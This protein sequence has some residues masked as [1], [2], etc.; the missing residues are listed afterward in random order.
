MPQISV[1]KTAD[2]ST[3][4]AGGT[5]HYTVT[6]TNTG[7]IAANGTTVSDPIP[8]GIASQ[9]WVCV[10]NGGATCAASGNGAISDTIATFPAGA[11]AVYTTTAIVAANPPA[12][13]VNTVSSTPPAGG[14]CS[15]GGT[16]PPCTATVSTAATAPTPQVS[17]SKTENIN[18]LMPG[19]TVVYTVTV[20]NVGSV[21]VTGATVTDPLPSGISAFTWTCTGSGGAVCPN[22]SGS[23][24]VAETIATFPAGSTLIY[25][26]TATIAA[27]PPGTVTN[28]ASL[29]PPG[30]AICSPSGN[31]PPCQ[32]TAVGTVSSVQPAPAPTLNTW[33]KIFLLLSLLGLGSRAVQLSRRQAADRRK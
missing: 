21:A 27:S 14:L 26:I 24:A 30:L 29:T 28:T 32:A 4:A 23:G 11:T 18:T 2:V 9:T 15:P 5:V 22:A 31:P 25:S 13:I 3:V 16:A 1:T 17:I 10:P 12:T 20:Q 19:G 8:A 6:V 33:M 7:S